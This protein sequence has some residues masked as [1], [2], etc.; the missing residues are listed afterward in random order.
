MVISSQFFKLLKRTLAGAT[1]FVVI[2]SALSGLASITSPL[3]VYAEDATSDSTTGTDSSTGVDN[4]SP[5]STATNGRTDDST[6]SSSGTTVAAPIAA[7]AAQSA[8]A[9]KDSNGAFTTTYAL[10][11]SFIAKII[12]TIGSGL[13]L[14][15]LKVM[16]VLL[17]P[18]L[19]YNN[20]ANSGIIDLGW[21][22]VRDICNMVVIL[23]L[24]YMAV[25]K[26][27][28]F[29]S[30]ELEQQIPRLFIGVVAMNF[31]RTICGLL[32]DA[33]QVV[34]LTFVNALMEIAAG[35]FQELFQLSS[36]SRISVDAV[37]DAWAQSSTVGF[38]DATS[39]II[40]AYFRLAV[41]GAVL[42]VL[43]ML[44]IAFIWRIVILWV[45]VI[46]S[47]P[48]FLQYGLKGITS[49]GFNPGE[50]DSQ[51]FSAL[52]MGPIL[53]FFLWL[54]LAAASNGGLAKS[55]AFPEAGNETAVTGL[56][57]EAF[58]NSEFVSLLLA[59]VL[60]VVGMRQAA[61]SASKLGG[62]ASTLINE[63]MGRRVARTAGLA[64]FRASDRT[65][66]GAGRA[67]SKIF[68]GGAGL[69]IGLA[70]AG[71]EKAG[72]KKTGDL[73]KKAGKFVGNIDRALVPYDSLESS[74]RSRGRDLAKDAGKGAIGVGEILGKVPG[75]KGLG[76]S[77]I[78]MGDSL[79]GAV[80]HDN[81]AMIK[82]AK[83]S[84]SHMSD[85][86]KETRLMQVLRGEGL[87]T[88]E[89]E[90]E[91][92]LLKTELLTNKSLQKAAKKLM[93]DSKFN[94]HIEEIFHELDHDDDHRREFMDDNK[95]NDA[96]SK[97]V[98][99]YGKAIEDQ[100]RLNGFIESDDFNG[101]K[102]RSEAVQDEDVRKALE[103]AR[104]R[105]DSQGNNVSKLDEA[106]RGSYGDA[107]KREMR[108]V[109]PAGTAPKFKLTS[110]ASDQNKPGK[111]LDDPSF[112]IP[113]DVPVLTAN[114]DARQI[115][116]SNISE[117]DFSTRHGDNLAAALAVS[118]KRPE[119]VGR[120]LPPAQAAR[121]RDEYVDRLDKLVSSGSRYANLASGIVDSHKIT[122]AERT[123]G[124][125]AAQAE[126]NSRLR[127]GGA[128]DVRAVSRMI[129]NDSEQIRHLRNTI[130]GGA[131]ATPAEIEAIQDAVT[132]SLSE[133][134]IRKLYE[135]F[136]RSTNPAEQDKLRRA[137]EAVVL[138]VNAETNRKVAAA[139]AA[140][141]PRTALP[142]LEE[143]D[144]DLDKLYGI[145]RQVNRWVGLGQVMPRR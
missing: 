45:A 115:D 4:S 7:Q 38:M 1:L 81:E 30:V 89:N 69:G 66:V 106:I 101:K 99:L 58:E 34:M 41:H 59:L 47:P 136:S 125:P 126:L 48:R 52:T 124:E 8:Q 132:S 90:T 79:K 104:S 25:L 88:L 71:L 111:P 9:S 110:E 93:G 2:A 127:P 16:E 143:I 3:Y 63:K 141:P 27:T 103:K 26:I 87:D 22:L 113:I 6:P 116:V 60:L 49:L 114:I 139:T 10:F 138:S 144:K 37:T 12:D 5:Y 83:D 84:I 19:Q 67:T 31:S 20:F 137:L 68:A 57:L 109:G 97:F 54:S 131:G 17:I 117:N 28:G 95:W 76:D 74:V 102:M 118:G 85:Q 82:A 53:A 142:D 65:I 55:E 64:A 50:W 108:L 70:G 112:F 11:A 123:G 33:S 21:P 140:L 46:L 62:L 78:R 129:E 122:E 29:G 120:N 13:G 14:M 145:S 128:F 44:A 119:Q 105:E 92:N 51:F 135:K 72:F 107:T 36:L 42:A 96:R 75:L 15:I 73:T 56:S 121:A 32:I 39:F 24:L 61:Q 43:I 18:I 77:A 94:G 80:H 100:G 23:V 133:E 134:K 130:T 40:N 91:G 98:D 35:N 86:A